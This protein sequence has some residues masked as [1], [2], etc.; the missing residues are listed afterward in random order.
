MG[1]GVPAKGK[2]KQDTKAILTAIMHS[3]R[4]LE[5]RR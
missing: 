4:F 1:A 3:L 2:E 5:G